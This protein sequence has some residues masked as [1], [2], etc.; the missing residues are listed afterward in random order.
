MTPEETENFLKAV[1]E[2]RQNSNDLLKSLEYE[3]IAVERVEARRAAGEKKVKGPDLQERVKNKLNSK[4]YLKPL[5]RTKG[6]KLSYDPVQRLDRNLKAF[7]AVTGENRVAKQHEDAEYVRNKET[8]ALFDN[9]DRLTKQ[10]FI[11]IKNG[12]PE[13]FAEFEK[14]VTQDLDDEE[15]AEFY[16]EVERLETEMQE[17]EDE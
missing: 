9:M 13:K 3:K 5:D 17:P 4:D 16:A 10:L 6:G 11:A 8:E 14:I 2:K 7:Y 15:L 12:S 1:D